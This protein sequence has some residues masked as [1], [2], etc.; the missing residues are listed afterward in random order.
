MAV[1]S[2]MERIWDEAVMAQ[3]KV[4]SQYPYGGTEQNY[5]DL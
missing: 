3:Y 2:K 1:N 4:L 5:E